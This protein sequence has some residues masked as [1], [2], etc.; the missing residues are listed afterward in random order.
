VFENEDGPP[1]L[2]R[3]LPHLSKV[4]KEIRLV[5]LLDSD[6]FRVVASSSIAEEVFSLS[7]SKVDPDIDVLGMKLPSSLIVG[8]MAG[9]RSSDL[10][11]V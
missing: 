2:R 6:P 8:G 5:L 9:T 7:E 1:E 10:R 11:A 3:L 4:E